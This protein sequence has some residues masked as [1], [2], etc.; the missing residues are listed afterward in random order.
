MVVIDAHNHLD[1]DRKRETFQTADILVERLNRFEIDMSVIMP[2]PLDTVT[3]IEEPN[4]LI[5][6]AMKKY[7]ERFIGFCCVNPFFKDKAVKEI[8]RCLNSGFK[9]IGEIVP[10][11]YQISANDGA[12]VSLLRD[13]ENFGI[14]ILFHVGD[15]PYCRP[16]VI[17]SIISELP[18]NVIIMGHMG[19]WKHLLNDVISIAKRYKKVYLDTADVK[20]SDMIKKAL[21]EVGAEK[22]LFGSD[23]FSHE[24]M[25]GELQK[26]ELLGLTNKE[27]KLIMGEN[28]ARLLKLIT[29]I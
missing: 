23:S 12:L 10:D 6:E 21:D 25:Q 28:V 18:E 22:I 9:G 7:P 24:E 15:T 8:E 11:A 20:S 29:R 5:F 27:K 2:N 3:R 26:I 16:K 17:E 13:I 14:P 4:N 19:T 1:N